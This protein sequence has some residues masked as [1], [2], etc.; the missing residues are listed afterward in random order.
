MKGI[1]AADLVGD[2]LR[3]LGDGLGLLRLLDG[4]RV[5]LHDVFD[6]AIVREFLEEA[7]LEYLIDLVAA[8]LDGRNRLRLPLRFLFDVVDGP[9][10]VFRSPLVAPAQ[11]GNDDAE[12]RELE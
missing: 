2:L 9:S 12:A 3:A 5:S 8:E 11:V 7:L 10:Q 1:G 4:G 6:V